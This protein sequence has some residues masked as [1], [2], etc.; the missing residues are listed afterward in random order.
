MWG[1]EFVP[2]RAVEGN[3]YIYAVEVEEEE[4]EYLASPPTVNKSG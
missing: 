4:E 2:P 3:I 1:V